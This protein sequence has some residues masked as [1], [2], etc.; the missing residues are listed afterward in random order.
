M[1]LYTH[2]RVQAVQACCGVIECH[3]YL[4]LYAARRAR[5]TAASVAA[6]A[7]MADAVRTSAPLALAETSSLVF[8][9]TLGT[10]DRDGTGAAG[11]G[12]AEGRA[13]HPPAG[14]YCSLL[15]TVCL[16]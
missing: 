15:H 11:L 2:M 1:R 13:A 3:S 6:S 8:R 7:P 16:V 5:A 12:D 9:L 10:A 14:G 4:S